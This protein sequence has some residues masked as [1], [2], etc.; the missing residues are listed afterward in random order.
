MCT[1]R[2]FAT[3]C[4]VRLPCIQVYFICAI[5]F[6]NSKLS[7][8]STVA[9]YFMLKSDVGEGCEGR[10]SAYVDNNNARLKHVFVQHKHKPYM[11]MKTRA[12]CLACLI[13]LIWS[14]CVFWIGDSLVAT[15]VRGRIFVSIVNGVARS[16]SDV[17]K[18][19]KFN[20]RILSKTR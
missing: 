4:S 2:H 20:Y 12:I 15:R 7:P 19:T 13:D 11:E 5:F 8:F 18:C 6:V 10:K 3:V 16:L 1:R 9:H 14:L 17:E